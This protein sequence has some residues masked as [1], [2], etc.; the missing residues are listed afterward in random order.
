[1]QASCEI[2]RVPCDR[3][4]FVRAAA[5]NVADDYLSRCDADT[6]FQSLAVRGLKGLDCSERLEACP[7]G[8]LGMVLV[9]HRPSEIRKHAVSQ[10][11]GDVA[12]KARDRAGDAILIAARQIVHVFRVKLRR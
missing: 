2:G 6:G 10:I 12:P 8:T 1:L 11:F 5:G 3:S 7:N 4:A 9:S